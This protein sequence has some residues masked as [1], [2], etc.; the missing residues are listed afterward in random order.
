MSNPTI[1]RRPN[2]A[3]QSKLNSELQKR[4]RE[5]A[6]PLPITVAKFSPG[7]SFVSTLS[8]GIRFPS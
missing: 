6:P 1:W 8:L 4:Y 2:S 3:A 7:N 5:I